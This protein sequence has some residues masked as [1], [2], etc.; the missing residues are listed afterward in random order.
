MD[1]FQAVPMSVKHMHFALFVEA[2][3]TCCR[4]SAEYSLPPAYLYARCINQRL[5]PC[6]GEISERTDIQDTKAM[7]L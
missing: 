7:I 3:L 4:T 1:I 2:G 5:N 6:D